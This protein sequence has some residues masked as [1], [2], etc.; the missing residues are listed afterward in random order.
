MKTTKLVLLALFMV[1][2]MTMV[3]AQGNQKFAYVDTD[4]ILQNIP[5]YG[6]AQEEINQ[7]SVGWQKEL[8]AL[9]DK[10]DQMKRDYQTESVLL[11]D[12]MKNK[13][14][15]A[16]AAKEQE[17]AALQ[18]Q[19]FGPEGELFTKRIELIQ[20]IQEKVYNAINQVAQVKNYSFVFDKASGSTL[21][22][23]SD[24]LD[25]S[26]DVLDEIG[27]VM[28]TV[29]RQD[30]KRGGNAG[31]TSASGSKGNSGGNK[32]NSV[33]NKGNAGGNKGNSGSTKP[34]EKKE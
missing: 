29:R 32:G 17:L 15:A 33:G 28:Q 31:S 20:P 5:E 21:L 23:C 4:Y 12:D 25:I 13:K 2:G 14:E 7:M 24:K 18:M 3:K 1:M 22:Y 30:R 27:N 11:S 26:D 16:I 19:Y 10:L 34:I 6:D 8:K 9:R